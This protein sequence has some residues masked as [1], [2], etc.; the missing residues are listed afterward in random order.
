MPVDKEDRGANPAPVTVNPVTITGKTADNLTLSVFNSATITA[1][2]T[3]YIFAGITLPLGLKIDITGVYRRV[4]LNSV[5]RWELI[6]CVPCAL[7]RE[8]SACIVVFL[9]S[10]GQ[11]KQKRVE[12]KT[13]LNKRISKILKEEGANC[14][15]DSSEGSRIANYFMELYMQKEGTYEY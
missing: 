1:G 13:A 3:V 9:D 7:K 10:R 14:K 8:G 12:A 15:P 11:L 5:G 2:L 6:T 4:R